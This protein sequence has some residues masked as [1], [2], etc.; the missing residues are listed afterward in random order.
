MT[1]TWKE[2]QKQYPQGISLDADF[3]N[4][5]HCGSDSYEKAIHIRG[6]FDIP[7]GQQVDAADIKDNAQ[8]DEQLACANCKETFGDIMSNRIYIWGE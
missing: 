8:Y 6:S 4:C 2:L 3:P 7:I 5:P 1:I